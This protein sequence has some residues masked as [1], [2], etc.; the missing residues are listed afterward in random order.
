MPGGRPIRAVFL[1]VGGTLLHEEPSRFE[2]Y[3]QAALAR[4]LDATPERVR[5]AMLAAHDALPRVSAGHFRYSE[6]WFAQLIER[7]FVG[8]LGLDPSLVGGVRREIFARF[9]DPATFRLYPGAAELVRE[10]RARALVVGAI[11]NWSERLPPILES[12]GLGLDFA[13]VSALERHEKPEPELFRL[14]LARAGVEASAALHAGDDLERDVQGAR[15]VG[16]LPVLV[17]RAGRCEHA[18]CARV[19]GLDELLRWIL[20]RREAT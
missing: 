13:L 19:A 10:L 14:A 20:E 11:S 3:R 15:A 18:D 7:V 4:G 1:D 8:A 12:L 6:G 16:I 5:A 2:I 9:A 17:D